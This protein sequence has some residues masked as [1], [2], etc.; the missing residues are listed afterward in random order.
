MPQTPRESQHQGIL[1]FLHSGNEQ[2]RKSRCEKRR[3]SLGPASTC[4]AA[5]ASKGYSHRCF[6]CVLMEERRIWQKEQLQ[7]AAQEYSAKCPGIVDIACFMKY[8][9]FRNGESF[10][11]SLSRDI[12]YFP[13]KM[14][15]HQQA[16]G[17]M[18]ST[19]AVWYVGQ[20]MASLLWI[21]RPQKSLTS[22]MLKNINQ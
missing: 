16:L 3:F 7:P 18:T 4:Q 15:L 11:T 20:T 10:F 5:R 2:Q 21:L 6:V 9:Q 14:F 1:F 22:F 19:T 12:S 8:I 17:R 13:S